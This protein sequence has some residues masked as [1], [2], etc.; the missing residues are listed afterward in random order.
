LFG[1]F[2]GDYAMAADKVYHCFNCNKE[3]SEEEMEKAINM[4]TSTNEEDSAN[5]S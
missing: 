4:N 2:F 5:P 1:F 3:F